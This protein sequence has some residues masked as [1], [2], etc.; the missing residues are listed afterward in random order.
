MEIFRIDI[1]K[2][3]AWPGSTSDWYYWTN[4][5]HFVGSGP[6]DWVDQRDLLTDSDQGF[7]IDVVEQGAWKVTRLSDGVVVNELQGYEARPFVLFPGEPLG[8]TGSLFAIGLYAD[9][10]RWYK[11]YRFPVRAA[12]LGVNGLLS[13]TTYN[14]F[15][16]KVASAPHTAPMTNKAGSPLVSAMLSPYV[17]GWQWRDGTKR[18]SRSVLWP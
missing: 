13:D 17:H 16:P 6:N 18:R 5:Y 3:I 10:T 7:H 1:E 4:T 11:R 12:D 9:G 15:A 2:R 8:I 14:H